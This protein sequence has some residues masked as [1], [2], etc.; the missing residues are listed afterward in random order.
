M[1]TRQD[2]FGDPRS[3]LSG[4]TTECLAQK[5]LES[6]ADGCRVAITG[7]IHQT[8]HES[9]EVVGAQVQPGL[10]TLL[11]SKDGFGEL[12]QSADFDLEE[13][14]PRIR[15]EELEEILRRVRLRDEP[16]C[17]ACHLV[18]A[19]QDRDI[20]HAVVVGGGRVHTEEATLPDDVSLVIEAFDSDVVEVRRPM[21]GRSRVRLAQDQAA[22]LACLG[23]NG[24]R[25][26]RETQ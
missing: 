18:F 7:Q 16:E 19:T 25:Q 12:G 4:N 21:H 20:H 22:G 15:L 6:K 9:A 13:L 11:E 14:I 23:P 1:Q 2:R 26:G 8:G 3:E 17:V 10:P 24:R 5:V